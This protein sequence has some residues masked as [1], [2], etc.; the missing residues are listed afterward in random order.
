ME[1][2]E[3]QKNTRERIRIS[4]DEFHGYSLINCRVYFRTD[5]GEWRPTRKGIALSKQ[6]INEVIELLKEAGKKLKG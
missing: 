6:N 5:S 4:I 3:L 1:I 2:G